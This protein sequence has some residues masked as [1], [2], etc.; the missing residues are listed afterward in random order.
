MHHMQGWLQRQCPSSLVGD[1]P[2]NSS[3]EK[4]LAIW[5]IIQATAPGAQLTAS[6]PVTCTNQILYFKAKLSTSLGLTRNT[7]P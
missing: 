6:N 3:T 5:G 1:D 2:T 4:E 7:Y